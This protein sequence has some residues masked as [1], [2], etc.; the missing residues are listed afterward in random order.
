MGSSLLLWLILVAQPAKPAPTPAPQTQKEKQAAPPPRDLLPEYVIGPGDGL[1]L[2]VWKETEL[3]RELHVRI[4]GRITVPLLGD[5]VADG[6]TPMQLASEL[7][8]ALG[9]YV[10]AP[11]VNVIVDQAGS[12]KVFVIGEVKNT[13]ALAMTGRMT[14]LQALALSGGFAQFANTDSILVIRGRQTIK[15]NYDKIKDG[16]DLSQNLVMLAGDTIV[17]R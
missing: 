14:I 8:T 3:S 11:V 7:A 4:D 5:I 16:S 15:V 6:K 1:Q 9:R 13:G 12:A 10:E 17:V 2:F